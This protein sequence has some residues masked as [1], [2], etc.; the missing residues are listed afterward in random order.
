M[1]LGVLDI[2]HAL[3]V[4]DDQGQE[5]HHH[6]AP[7]SDIAIEEVDRVGDAHVFGGFVDVIDEGID[8]AREV[9]GSGYL[10]VGAGGGFSG[11]VGGGFKVTVACLGLH[12]VGDQAM[13]A[14]LDQVFFFQAQV[15]VAIRLI[16]GVSPREVVR[17]DGCDG[18]NIRNIQR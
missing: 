4:A 12:L 17:Q 16:H 5:R 13:L 14:T 7:V 18:L 3:V 9:V 2:A 6:H 15:G 10:D 1:D 8:A 11:E